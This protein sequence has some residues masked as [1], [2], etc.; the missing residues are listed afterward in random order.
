M[1]AS[2]GMLTPLRMPDLLCDPQ[3]RD[4][5]VGRRRIFRSYTNDVARTTE[6]CQAAFGTKSN[7]AG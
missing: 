7:F 4:S 1:D 3:R 5:R 2:V 6:T